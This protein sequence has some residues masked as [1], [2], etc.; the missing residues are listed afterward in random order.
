MRPNEARESTTPDNICESP[1]GGPRPLAVTERGFSD[2]QLW[3]VE[4]LAR[5]L[6]V[7]P[8][9]IDPRESFSNY[10]LDSLTAV[11]L[12]GEL[13]DHFGLRLAPTLLWNYPTPEAVA[14]HIAGAVC[15]DE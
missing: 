5:H 3:I 11:S 1:R 15:P 8:E 7:P 9:S 10:G 6:Q 4:Y 14:L 2:I 12:S 13:E